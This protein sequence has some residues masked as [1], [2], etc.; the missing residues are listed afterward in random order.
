MPNPAPKRFPANMPDVPEKSPGKDLETLVSSIDKELQELKKF[1]AGKTQQA[2]IKREPYSPVYVA[3][4]NHGTLAEDDT[5]E[6]ADGHPP[7]NTRG[8]FAVTPREAQSIADRMA[9]FDQEAK[10]LERLARL[11]RQNRRLTILNAL[12][13]T[14]M[15]G[16]MLVS[17]F[18]L[19]HTNTLDRLNLIQAAKG[20]IWAPSVDK[21][22]PSPETAAKPLE[23]Q[24]QEAP[25]PKE[26]P[27][28]A[29][30]ESSRPADPPTP[31]VRLE[32]A[33]TISPQETESPPLTTEAPTPPASQVS[34]GVASAPQEPATPTIK[35]V[36]SITSDKYHYPDCKWAKTIIPRKV[37]GFT[38][39]AEAKQA[40]YRQCPTCKPPLTDETDSQA[41]MRK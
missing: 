24:A 37:R 27:V 35:Y 2:G 38:S 39:V 19:L 15:V 40:G 25:K 4:V 32:A 17:A 14:L 10:I 7:L 21:N 26:A 31:P 33:S 36:G 41:E 18:L 23:V 16:F 6:K 8:Q 28:A 22:S 1:L 3:P 20:L 12:F 29:A 13:C 5:S 34:P 11:E 9:R 30:T